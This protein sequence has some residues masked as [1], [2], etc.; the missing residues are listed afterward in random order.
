MNR[1]RT[2]IL[3]AFGIGMSSFLVRWPFGLGVPGEL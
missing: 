1:K 2:I 3:S